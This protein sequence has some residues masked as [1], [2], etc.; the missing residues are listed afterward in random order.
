MKASKRLLKICLTAWMV[1]FFIISI[2]SLTLYQT[3]KAAELPPT[4]TI[5]KKTLY[6]GYADYTIEFKNLSQKA[7]VSYK[8][9]NSKVAAVSSRGVVKPIAKGTASITVTIKQNNI[10]Y[11]RKIA[12]TV[13]NPYVS[14]TDSIDKLNVGAT[15]QFKAKAYG[16]KKPSIEWSSSDQNIATIVKSTGKLTAKKPGTVM[17]TGMDKIS[18]KS[19][20]VKI[21]IIGNI[22]TPTPKPV[23]TPTP[24]PSVTPTPKPKLEEDYIYTTVF[25]TGFE[26]DTSGF[27][28]RGGEN[29]NRT[30]QTSKSGYYSLLASGRTASW[31]GPVADM[32]EILKP[33]KTYQITTWVKYKGNESSLR[34]QSTY[35][36][37]NGASYHGIGSVTAT[38]NTW[39]KFE[40][41]LFVPM[42]ITNIKVYFE[43]PQSISGEIYLDDFII[44][45]VSVNTEKYAGLPSISNVYKDYF[46]IGAAVSSAVLTAD[47]TNT[48]IKSQFSTITFGN[49]M[50]PDALLDYTAC[51]S[52]LKQYNLSPAI[53]TASLEDYLKYAKDNG[54]KVRFHTL[55]WHE[56]T[57]RW[58]FAVNYSTNPSAP[59]VS[60][61]VMLKRMENYIRKVMLCTKQ[62][63][64]VIYAWDV[65]NEAIEPNHNKANGYRADNS[66]W[67]QIIGEEF[68]EKA[69]EYARKYS[70]DDAGLFYNDYNTYIPARTTAIYN[71]ASKLK[72]KGLIDG[73]GMQSHIDMGYPSLDMYEKAVRKFAEL[74]LEINIT[75]LDMHNNQNTEA[76]FQQQ[77]VRY[78]DLF[79]LLLR[80]K[81]E[82]VANITNVTFW[83]VLD[84]TSWLTSHRREKSYPLLFDGE[85]N[86]KPAFYKLIELNN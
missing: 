48:L 72:E 60:K 66:L 30:D 84:S 61:D 14:I 10:T 6:V 15:Y 44:S 28:G 83:G 9:N 52:D 38:N 76:A 40:A 54:F 25:Q 39:V 79:S 55:L 36:K 4:T 29:V 43:L 34:I 23:A 37:N 75:E 47:I 2:T 26:E 42:D 57:P 70:Y 81:K 62:Y 67:Y 17:I 24:K 68:V 8:T 18:K 5:T 74:G 64:G 35:D 49:E 13:K 46:D 59:L 3:A 27:T 33:G 51:I 1:S 80:L 63:P 73:I 21:Q 71:L 12:M 65:V 7:T 22:P 53:K 82:G 16:I 78:A 86:P 11:T 85:G 32:T 41:T 50:K 31:Q 19:A 56:Q 45:E 77:A 69:F 58:F 20:T